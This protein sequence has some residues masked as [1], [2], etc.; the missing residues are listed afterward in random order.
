MGNLEAVQQDFNR[1]LFM[2]LDPIVQTPPSYD[3]RSAAK[4]ESTRCR[5]WKH[6]D[7]ASLMRYEA[8][9]EDEASAE[10]AADSADEGSNLCTNPNSQSRGNARNKTGPSSS[11]TTRSFQ[12]N[13]SFHDVAAR[14]GATS[15]RQP[16]ADPPG[17]VDVCTRSQ[18]SAEAREKSCTPWPRAVSGSPDLR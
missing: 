3:S 7:Y 15:V 4:P 2:L 12:K 13:N 18:S 10:T 16:A 11:R 17:E 5:M 8:D 1:N 9:S 14:P 6:G